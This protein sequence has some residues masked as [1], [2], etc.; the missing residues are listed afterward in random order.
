MK[1]TDLKNN[2]KRLG[3]TLRQVETATGLSNAYISQLENGKIKK[4]S[5]DTIEKL[6]ALYAYKPNMSNVCLCPVCKSENITDASQYKNNGIYGPGSRSW[7][8]FDASIC[9]NCGVYF[10]KVNGNG[11]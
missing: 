11:I 4:P 3:L 10:K 5:Y 2:R 1:I 9:N 6:T 8:T 7:R